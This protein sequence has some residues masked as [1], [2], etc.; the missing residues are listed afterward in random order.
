MGTQLVEYNERTA[1]L[2]CK[3]DLVQELL[4]PV[5]LKQVS[6]GILFHLLPLMRNPCFTE[7][8]L[9]IIS[10]ILRVNLFL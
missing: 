2:M 4:C 8:N 5:V 1:S 10:I 6:Y 7:I 3:F 9:L